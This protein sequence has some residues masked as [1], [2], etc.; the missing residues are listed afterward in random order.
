MAAV[1]LVVLIDL[2]GFGI[3]LPHLALYAVELKASPFVIGVLYSIY[4]VAQLVFSPVWGGLSDRIGRRPVMLISTLGASLSYVL[5]AF[6]TNLGMLFL[7][8][9][10]AGIMAGNISAAQAYVADVTAPQERA[11]GMG[12]IGAAFG[13]GFTVGPA[14]GAGLLH[15]SGPPGFFRDNPYAILG[16]FS[17]CL[18]LTSFMMVLKKLPE[19]VPQP[20]KDN[21]R[22]VRTSVFGPAFWKFLIQNRPSS[23]PWVLP[24]L[25]ASV[26]LLAFGQAN[27]YGTFPLFCKDILKLS[28]KEVGIQYAYMGLVAVVIQ[29]GLLQF[30]V[31]KFTEPRLFFTGCLLFVAGLGL[32][33]MAGSVLSLMFF[34]S[35]MSIGGS[36]SGPTV[37]SL[38]SQRAGP[39]KYG[40]MLGA[41]QGLAA[42]GRAIGPAWGGFLYGHSYRLPFAVTALV[43]SLTFIAGFKLKE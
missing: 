39:G 10:L 40:S 42:L 20:E 4:S 12:L 23:R 8:R 30:L 19:S 22:I 2:I 9:L 5:F 37:N 3:I 26:F 34:I 24:A 6:S 36:L 41:S 25:M 7:S 15:L 29:A 11:K 33:P 21:G 32:I 18:S 14:I 38:I 1:F 27:L 16:F 13:I 43:V 17:A 31:K 35:L 28:P